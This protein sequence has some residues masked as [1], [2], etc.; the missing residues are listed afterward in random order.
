[1]GVIFDIKRFAVHDGPGIRTTVFLKGCP[2]ACSWCHNP[3]SISAHIC[4][5]PKILRVG[6]MEFAENE[7]VGRNITVDELLV[8][9]KKEWVFMDESGGGVTFSGGE[10]FMQASFLKKAL[11]ACGQEGMHTIVDTSGYASLEV[12]KQV[13]EHTNLF[14]F[15]LKLMNDELHQ[16][17]TGVSNQTILQNLE[18]LLHA[19][20]Q[21]RI[22][23]PLVPGIT[24][25]DENLSEIIGYLSPIEPLIEGIDLLPYHTT[26]AHKY[27]R[28]GME[29]K[30]AHIKALSDLEI[31]RIKSLF[32]KEG[33]KVEVGG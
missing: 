28:F 15:D 23:V 14:L 2:L 1:M 24:A 30:T 17:F 22:R 3:E 31:E 20:Q 9:L 10:P 18:W 26:A 8:E 6:N 11:Q 5:V 33:L 27:V 16:Q 32:E 25:T 7:T 29:H 21:V 4:T 13:A 19:G 12:V